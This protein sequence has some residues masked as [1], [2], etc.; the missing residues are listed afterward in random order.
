M[1]TYL[2][3]VMVLLTAS[4]Y[5]QGTGAFATDC[6]TIEQQ[7]AAYNLSKA[8]GIVVRDTYTQQLQC[9]YQQL[10][11]YYQQLHKTN[12]QIAKDIQQIAKD[13]QQIAK[14][15]QQV[16]TDAAQK[17]KALELAAREALIKNNEEECQDMYTFC[18]ELKLICEK[19][20]HTDKEISDHVKSKINHSG[21]HDGSNP[22]SSTQDNGGILNPH[23]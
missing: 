7:Q 17:A 13:K 1:K 15:A 2:M 6:P 10:G 21:L 14:D 5:G 4:V 16:A 8:A 23:N 20:D 22:G 12:Q 3:A 18:C 9:H 19:V 11:T